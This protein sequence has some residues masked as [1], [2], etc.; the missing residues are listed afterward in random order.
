MQFQADILGMEVHRPEN[1]ESTAMG[2][3]FLAG[4]AAGLWEKA[5]DLRAI[6]R[7]DRIFSPQIDT[8]ER[9]RLYRKW[10]RAVK[11]AMGWEKP[12]EPL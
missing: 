8:G 7:M 12:D 2:A 5:E 10:G 6:R 9:D 4:L 1:T 3:A 11:C